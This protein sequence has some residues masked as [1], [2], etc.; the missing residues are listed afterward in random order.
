MMIK[1]LRRTLVSGLFSV[2]VLSSSLAA[3]LQSGDLVIS[4][5]LANPAG[6]SDGRGEW[7]E[8]FNASTSAIDLRGLTLADDG[9]DAHV[10]DAATPLL[11]G[12]GHYFVLG[13]SA[14]AGRAGA[15][16]DY[17]YN[18]FVLGNGVDEIVL[19][20]GG[21]EIWRVDYDAALAVAGQSAELVSPGGLYAPTPATLLFSAGGDIGSPGL[22]GS[23]ALRVALL[24][25]PSPLLLLA[26]GLMGLLAVARRRGSG[27]GS[28]RGRQIAVLSGGV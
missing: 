25:L 15:T 16:P 28:A 7:V 11:I 6:L 12:S 9:S 2:F 4:E 20:Q 26:S 3:P 13:R 23:L 22:P 21:S 10:I 8:L 27:G 17:V 14:Q 24:L 18:G 1:I 5:F 19:R